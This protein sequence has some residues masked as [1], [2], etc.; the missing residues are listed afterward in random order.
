MFSSINLFILTFNCAKALIDIQA[1]S[2][3]LSTSVKGSALPDLLV[4]SL[5]EISPLPHAF[6]GGAFLTPYITRFHDAI[7]NYTNLI[8]FEN[9]GQLYV[10]VVTHNIGTT[11]L[12]IY[13]KKISVI[14]NIEKAGVGVG[15]WGMGSKG[16]A[17]VRLKFNEVEFTF[18]AAHFAA[19]ERGLHKRNKDWE[20]IVRG[21]VFYSTRPNGIGDEA[22][23]TSSE[24][25]NSSIYKTTSHLFLAGDL[26]Y[27]TSLKPPAAHDHRIFPQPNMSINDTHHFLN[28]FTSDQLNQARLAGQTCHGLSEAKI[29]FPP[30]YKYSILKKNTESHAIQEKK[31]NWTPHRWPSWC[32]RILFLD[33]PIWQTSR[34]PGIQIKTLNYSSLPLLP[35]SDHQPVALSL[36][37]PL[38]QIPDP[39]DEEDYDDPRVRPPFYVDTSSKNRRDLIRKLEIF[40][41]SG[42]WLTTTSEGGCLLAVL[43]G[44]VA[45]GLLVKSKV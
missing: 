35:N 5:Q 27:R 23:L 40:V 17:A 25:Q 44:M 14:E 19:M 18:V 16:A 38:L 33:L 20:N 45:I 9:S 12:I 22:L 21:L 37:M 43:I 3:L 31:W 36:E 10:P 2:S 4:F 28:L 26:N 34:Y 13:A 6:I 7:K 41:G 30:T 15:L 24:Y 29:T 8:D 11:C 32:D 42:L 39:S 1:F